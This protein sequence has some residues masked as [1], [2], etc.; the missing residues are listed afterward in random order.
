M[1]KNKRQVV[2]STTEPSKDCLWLKLNRSNAE[3]LYYGNNGW[4]TLI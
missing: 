3:L 2:E 1:D 4:E